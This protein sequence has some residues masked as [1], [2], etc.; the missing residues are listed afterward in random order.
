[1]AGRHATCLDL[2]NVA[3]AETGAFRT[4]VTS[5]GVV[6]SFTGTLGGTRIDVALTDYTD[7]APA[8]AFTPPHSSR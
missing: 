8:D 7:S 1:V 6:G 3:K 2:R 4:C 5:D